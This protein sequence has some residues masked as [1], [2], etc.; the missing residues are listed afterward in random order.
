[1]SP[2]IVTETV[3]ALSRESPPVIPDEIVVITTARGEA[4]LI[5]DLLTPCPEWNH[6]TVWQSL[7]L[8][9]L[10]TSNDPRLILKPCKVISLHD[11]ELGI[12]SPL[13]D[14]RSRADNAAAAEAILDEVRRITANDDTRLIAS[15]AGGRK[16]MGALLSSALSLLGR[17]GD[18][19]THI[20][21]NDPFDSPRL[22]PRFYFPPS[23]PIQYQVAAY[24]HSET[25][26]S[27][28]NA[29]L[30]LADVPFVPLR[31]LFSDHLGRL[32]GDFMELVQSA[33]RAVEE[34]AGPVSLWLDRSRWIAF[35]NHCPLKLTGRD[36]PF[37]D[38]LYERVR[39]GNP[40]IATHDQ[41]VEPFKRFFVDWSPLHPE[42]ALD[43]GGGEDWRKSPPTADDFRKRLNSLRERLQKAGLGQWVNRLLPRRSAVGFLVAGVKIA[44][45][46]DGNITASVAS[47]A[48][49]RE[50][51][52]RGAAAPGI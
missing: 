25:V 16:T 30:D 47:R 36:I 23:P 21:V 9:I 14:I 48:A 3:W 8:E 29:R 7:R 24:D 28:A 4:D 37:F 20:L 26:I 15:I 13:D 18:R 19:L 17:R 41:I 51:Q 32:P 42:V 52:K 22:Q 1:M 40:P 33:S 6:S 39:S 49:L 35:V 11:P 44:P 50:P 34:L 31:Y 45:P 38:F 5:R 43:K 2:A 46:N 27:S 12:A 10:G